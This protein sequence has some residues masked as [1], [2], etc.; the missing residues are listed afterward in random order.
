MADLLPG[1]GDDDF[2]L[3]GEYALGLLE[4]DELATARHRVLAERDFAQ[5]VEWWAMQFG[6]IAEASGS[7][8][9]SEDV[10]RGVVARLPDE[11][12]VSGSPAPLPSAPPE[13]KLPLGSAL[14]FTL[15]GGAIAAALAF[16]FLDIP[17]GAQPPVPI[18]TSAPERS[19]LLIAQ[20]SDEDA[21]RSLAAIVDEQRG[22]ISL[23]IDGFSPEAGQAP[24][25]WVIPADGVPRSLGYIPQ[26]GDFARQLTDAELG[27]L[28]DGASLAVTFEEDS[29][30][31]HEEPTPPILVAGAL[32]QV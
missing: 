24:E 10:W 5:A 9:P 8:Q 13:Q 7:A 12:S 19:P 18:E 3:A 1:M 15:L 31:P 26:S 6:P 30:A 23:A 27:L 4:G 17:R 29:G 2:A 11:G 21:G 20:L 22:D 28:N 14:G 32:N 16:V 25:L